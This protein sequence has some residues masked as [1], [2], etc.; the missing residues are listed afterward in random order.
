[1]L[2]LLEGQVCEAPKPRKK[3]MLFRISGNSVTFFRSSKNYITP[4]LIPSESFRIY[5][6]QVSLR[7]RYAAWT[8]DSVFK[9][10][11]RDEIT[12]SSYRLSCSHPFLTPVPSWYLLLAV[13][14]CAYLKFCSA[15][16]R[17]T[18]Y[19]K[20]NYTVC[21]RFVINWNR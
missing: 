15:A 2:L 5:R 8:N 17:M 6:L 4:W 19:R 9:E 14:R 12:H 11:T 13:G 3:A 21:S 7:R 16:R 1:M 10:A 20:S 18:C